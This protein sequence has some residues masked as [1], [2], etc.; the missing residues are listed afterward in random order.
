MWTIKI[1]FP[2]ASGTL[3]CNPNTISLTHASPLFQTGISVFFSSPHSDFL[4]ITLSG[5]HSSLSISRTHSLFPP[6]LSAS[7][8]ALFPALLSWSSFYLSSLRSQRCRRYPT[9]SSSIVGVFTH[10]TSAVG[11]GRQDKKEWAALYTRAVSVRVR[12]WG[13]VMWRGEKEEKEMRADEN[14]KNNYR[15]MCFC[16]WLCSTGSDRIRGTERA[17]EHSARKCASTKGKIMEY[18]FCLGKNKK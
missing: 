10:K 1:H 18:Y 4:S 6:A 16:T 12:I 17:N 13:E 7:A 2:L 8:L 9:A 14:G 15:K 5:L 11:V 3:H